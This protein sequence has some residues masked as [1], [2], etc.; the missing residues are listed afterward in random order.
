MVLEAAKSGTCACPTPSAAAAACCEAVPL[1]CRVVRNA[2]S[3]LRT[4][5]IRSNGVFGPREPHF[6]QRVASQAQVCVCGGGLLTTC[7]D[8]G[9]ACDPTCGVVAEQATVHGARQWQVRIGRCPCLRVL[10][11]P[12]TQSM[13]DPPS[14]LSVLLAAAATLWTSPTLATPCTACCW[15]L[16]A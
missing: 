6:I 7:F 14:F 3:G 13:C 8:L 10:A 4:C 2:G 12:L 1:T 11:M 9:P 15:P 16:Q 5:S